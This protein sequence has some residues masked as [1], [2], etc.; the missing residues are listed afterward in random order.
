MGPVIVGFIDT[1]EG[2]AAARTGAAE[3]GFRGVSLVLAT[4][5]GIRGTASASPEDEHQHEQLKAEVLQMRDE[6]TTEG[7]QV[8]TELLHTTYDA[9]TALAKFADERDA[10]VLVIGIRQRSRVG[11]LIIGS[12]T[13]TALLK[14]SCPVLT[15]KHDG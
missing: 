5:Q 1:P 11:K 7:L 8:E 3:A 4:H 6:I 2:R 15:V 9:G 12:S 13:Q 14:A 10:S